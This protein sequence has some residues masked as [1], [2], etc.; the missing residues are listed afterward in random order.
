M[1]SNNTT[2]ERFAHTQIHRHGKLIGMNVSTFVI[3]GANTIPIRPYTVSM[4]HP[5]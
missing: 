5:E 4:I 3:T 2:I 1:P